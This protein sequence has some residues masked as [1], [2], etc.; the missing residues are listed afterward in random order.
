MSPET[1][2]ALP[3]K[4]RAG[5]TDRSQA[6]ARAARHHKLLVH[7]TRVLLLVALT[8]LWE[9]LARAAVIDPF[10]FS[11]PSRIWNQMSQ[12]ALH[13]TPQGSL[14]EQIWY[15]LYEALLGW[16]I[17]VIG[18]VVLGIAL[19][20]I[21]FLADVLG[22]YI[23]VL[24]ALPRIVLAPIFLIW[25]GLGPASKVASAVV[26][27]FFP[28]FF[29]AFQGAREVD[30]NLVAN[31]RILG[32]SNRQVTLQVVIPSA[33]SWIFTSLHVSFGFALIGAIVGEYIGATKGLGLLVSAS[34]GTFNAA[35]VYAAMVILAVVAL[36]AEGLLAFLERRLFR[37]KPADAGDG[38]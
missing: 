27:V 10:N 20:R 12:W 11:M 1:E 37:W 7:G 26:L 13:G 25:F 16:V 9:W 31:S 17:G 22:P 34:Q 8:G 19:G 21:R 5:R 30:R 36:L 4:P 14:W 2:T 3:A 23:K 15:T 29:N 32:A 38:R 6:R 18:G 33:T 35:G 24:N 28:V